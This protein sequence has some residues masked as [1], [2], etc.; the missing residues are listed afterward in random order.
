M[1][2]DVQMYCRICKTR[3]TR[4]SSGNLTKAETETDHTRVSQIHSAQ[5]VIVNRFLGRY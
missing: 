3:N 5:Q 1:K 4:K 2:S